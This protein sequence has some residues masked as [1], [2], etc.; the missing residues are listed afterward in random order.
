[1]FFE[2]EGPRSHQKHRLDMCQLL[3]AGGD[4]WRGLI[5]EGREGLAE[6]EDE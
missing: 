4:L 5:P 6:E 2:D 1:M 3:S